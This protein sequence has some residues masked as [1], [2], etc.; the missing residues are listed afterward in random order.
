MLPQGSV[1]R[2][3]LPIRYV[4]P[5]T[6]ARPPAVPAHCQPPCLPPPRHTLP[7]LQLFRGMYGLWLETWYRFVPPQHWLV[8]HSDDLFTPG[9]QRDTLRAVAKHL[10]LR[11]PTEQELDAMVR[12]QIW[13]GGTGVVGERGRMGS[14]C[15]EDG[16]NVGMPG[17]AVCRWARGSGTGWLGS[18][19]EGHCESLLCRWLS[20]R[21]GWRGTWLLSAN[22]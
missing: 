1:S 10:G 19:W 6:F 2:A 16:C 17:V 3:P 15:W 12:G 21:Y 14:A 13:G 18:H 9:R 20:R 4:H 11:D 7:L 5:V 8:L 22:Q